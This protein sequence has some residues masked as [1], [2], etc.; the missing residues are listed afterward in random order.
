VSNGT[1][2]LNNDGS[3]DYTS[4]AGFD[5]TDNFTYEVTDGEFTATATVTITV[6]AAPPVNTPPTASDDAYSATSGVTLNVAAPGVLGNDTD[7]G[8]LVPLTVSTLVSDVSNGTLN[9]NNDG[10]FDYTSVAGFDGT[11]NFTYEVTDGEFTN[12]D[13]YGDLCSTSEYST[14][15]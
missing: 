12:S 2:N 9:L 6:T 15:C 1:L 7:D 5:G 10:S 14:D 4:V 8:L 3:F 11:D 13:Y